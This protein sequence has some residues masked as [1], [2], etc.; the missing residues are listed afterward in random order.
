MPQL[1]TP[2]HFTV[3]ADPRCLRGLHFLYRGEPSI[4]RESLAASLR[5]VFPGQLVEAE[6]SWGERVVTRLVLQFRFEI[7]IGDRDQEVS[8]IHR[9]T[10]SPEQRTGDRARFEALLL[11]VLT[12]GEQS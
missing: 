7:R 11:G 8:F 1:A 5:G 6:E 4:H 2:P 12:G 10:A 3:R 9:A